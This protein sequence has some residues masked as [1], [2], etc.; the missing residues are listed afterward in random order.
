MALGVGVDHRADGVESG[1]T[2][3]AGAEQLGGR[4]LDLLELMEE[5][6]MTRPR[7]AVQARLV[8][9]RVAV[10]DDESSSYP[11]HSDERRILDLPLAEE[12]GRL[13]HGM[14]P[15]GVD[16]GV[17]GSEIGFVSGTGGSWQ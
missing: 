17:S 12:A 6:D 14:A 3:G 16:H 1:L 10:V 15:G 13:V 8:R 9:G 4:D 5:G 11:E 2:P 7:E